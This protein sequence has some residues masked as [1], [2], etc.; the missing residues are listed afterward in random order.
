MSRRIASLIAAIA[1]VAI[2]Y[3]SL[4]SADTRVV[5]N[6]QLSVSARLS[7][8]RLPRDRRS[9]T[10]VAVGWKIAST[11]PALEPPA[12]KTVKIEINRHG[13]LDSTG[14][15]T[16]PYAKIQP[17]STA[18]ALANCRSSLVGKGTFS[19]QVGLEGQE[20]YVSQGKMLVFNGAK[21]GKP[22]LFGQIYTAYPFAASFVIVFAVGQR[23]H[24]AYGATLTAK[25]PPNLRAWGNLTEVEMRLARR[26]SYRGERRSF[27][28]AACPTPKGFTA[29]PFRLAKMRFAFL[30]GAGVSSTLTETCKVRR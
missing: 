29:A 19:A 12:L 25:L 22:V 15:P 4:A 13:A 27:L 5:G 2:L 23:T 10:A 3:S 9:P 26:F 17:A 16:C 6:L 11:D 24:G 30:G 28:S 18:R 7:P 14:L 20:R 8:K 1:V 21:G